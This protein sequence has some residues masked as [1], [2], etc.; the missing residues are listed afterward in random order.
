MCMF[1]NGASKNYFNDHITEN[2]SVTFSSIDHTTLIVIMH[3]L[4]ATVTG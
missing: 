1:D 4:C 2:I 3:T